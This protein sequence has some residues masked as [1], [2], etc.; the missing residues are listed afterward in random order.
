MPVGVGQCQ[1][2]I[3]AGA[4]L[5]RGD[6]HAISGGKLNRVGR[7]NY[8]RLVEMPWQ[9][10][11]H[12]GSGHVGKVAGRRAAVEVGEADTAIEMAV[13]FDGLPHRKIAKAIVRTTRNPKGDRWD[14]KPRRANAEPTGPHC[15]LRRWRVRNMVRT[16]WHPRS[17]G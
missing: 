6:Q 1:A 10:G 11:S 2:G 4:V 3:G 12:V 8:G 9:Q 16:Q 14:R 7:G 17:R 15:R 13:S 5:V